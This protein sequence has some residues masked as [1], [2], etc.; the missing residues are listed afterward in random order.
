MVLDLS[1]DLGVNWAGIEVILH[2]REQML[3]MQRQV[4]DIFTHLHRQMKNTLAE[5]QLD[6]QPGS[7]PKMDVIRILEEKETGS[8]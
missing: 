5:R 7:L 3:A 2:M 1:R 8:E 6:R 4:H